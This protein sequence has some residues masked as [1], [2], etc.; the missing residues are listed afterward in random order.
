[1]LGPSKLKD[2]LV[3]TLPKPGNIQTW[4][5]FSIL[6]KFDILKNSIYEGLY[7]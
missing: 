5:S 6:K 1:M 3:F 7:G 2:G 4:L